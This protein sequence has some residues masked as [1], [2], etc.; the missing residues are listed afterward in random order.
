MRQCVRFPIPDRVR[1]CEGVAPQVD[2]KLGVGGGFPSHAH[3]KEEWRIECSEE[4]EEVAV[5][6]R[7]MLLWC[8]TS[9]G[10]LNRFHAPG[11]GENII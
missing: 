4:E 7:L 11:V 3:E 1:K 10:L 2:R 6:L 8:V 9:Q 5:S